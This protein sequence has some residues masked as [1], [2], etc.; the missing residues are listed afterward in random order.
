MIYGR[1][2]TDFFVLDLSSNILA[3]N[4]FNYF[5]LSATQIKRTQIKSFSLLFIFLENLLV[6]V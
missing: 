6:F 3:A 4:C 5:I 2:T 1:C